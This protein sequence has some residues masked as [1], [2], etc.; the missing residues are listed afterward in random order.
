MS[1]IGVVSLRS[2]PGAAE[3]TRPVLAD[4][5]TSDGKLHLSLP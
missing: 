5:N 2:E 4:T 1:E 3:D